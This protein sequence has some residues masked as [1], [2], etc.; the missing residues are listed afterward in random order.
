MYRT[1]PMLAQ[2]Y[3]ALHHMLEFSIIR[4]RP[5]IVE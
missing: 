1:R 3:A 4:M 5:P 2:G